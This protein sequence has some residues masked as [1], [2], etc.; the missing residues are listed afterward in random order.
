MVFFFLFLETKDHFLLG[1]ISMHAILWST[2]IFKPKPMDHDFSF[3][4][5]FSSKWKAIKKYMDSP[6][7]QECHAKANRFS[8]E[9]R[10]V[11]QK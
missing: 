10:P 11:S 1:G 6:L 4:N 8:S 5:V 2:S 3:G 9:K 7:L